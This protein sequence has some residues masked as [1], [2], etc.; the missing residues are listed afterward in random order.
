LLD[1]TKAFDRLEYCKLVRSLL[2]KNLPSIVI[3][4][5]LQMYLFHFTQIA[6][7]GVLS[8]RFRVSNGVRQVA[9]SSPILFCIYFDVLL[10]DLSSPGIG[11]HIGLFIVGAFAYTDDLVSLAPSANAMRSML[12]VSDVY[13]SQSNVPFNVKN[14]KFICCHSNG[15][16]KCLPRPYS[17]P[18]LS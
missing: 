8:E 7:N 1:A 15:I 6:R 10:G 13:A 2:I 4:L 18:S 17:Y 3:R 16:S 5:L 9:I 14:S 12:H 11:C